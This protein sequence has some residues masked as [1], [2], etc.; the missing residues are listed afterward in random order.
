MNDI[1][2]GIDLGTTNSEVAVVRNGQVQLIEVEDAYLMPSA[3]GLDEEGG[4]LV[5]YAARNQ[6]ALHPERTVRSIKRRMGEDIKVP[7]GDRSY[8]PQEISAVILA[9]L[10]QAAEVQLGEPVRKAVITVPAYFSDAQRQAT[11][12]AGTLAGLE[13][14]RI[15]NEPTAAALAYESDQAERRHILVYDLGGGTFDVSVVRMEQDV[16]EVLASHGNNHLGGD[17]FDALIVDQLRAHVKDEHGIDPAD[18]PRAMARLRHTAEAAKMELSSAPIARIEEAYLLEG[19]NGPVNLSVDLTRADYEAMIEPLLDETLEA[20]RIALE[21][22]ELAVTDLDEIVLVGG[23]TRTPRIQQRLE[24]LL[25]LQPRSEIDPDLCV[26]MGAAIQGGV[27]AGEKVASMLVDVTPYTFGTSAIAELNGER[28]PYCFIP[29][30]R[31]NTPI[32]VTRSEAF[33]TSYDGQE[34]IDV[35]VFQGEDPDALNNTQIGSFRIEGLSDVPAGNVII[36]TFSLDVNGILHVSSVEKLTGKRKEITIDSATARFEREE[37]GAARE[38]VQDLI[39][40]DAATQQTMTDSAGYRST[41]LIERAERLLDHATPEDREDLVDA[42]EQLRDA[43][44][45]EDQAALEQAREALSDLVF[46]LES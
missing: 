2:I 25:G 37:M 5:G 18:D 27:I 41:E 29:V 4:L 21:D 9:R 45:Q 15:I 35:R 16:V 43:L 14:V 34:A 20:V 39:D 28:Y 1:I 46:Y 36:T 17:D 23:T 10:K 44:Q 30:I 26:A 32:P 3:V 8:T 12:D 11:R 7:L 31:K 19:R 42:I 38:R 22:A 13:V 6:L 40:S 33:F 24:E